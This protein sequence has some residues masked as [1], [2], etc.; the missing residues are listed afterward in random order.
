MST[1]R[2]NTL[3]NSA[4]AHLAPA[5]QDEDSLRGRVEYA[6]GA[7]RLAPARLSKGLDERLGLARRFGFRPDSPKSKAP[8]DNRQRAIVKLHFFGHGGGGAGALKA[9]VRYIAREDAGRVHELELE[10]AAR[11]KREA[12]RALEAHAGYLTRE[13]D[14]PPFYDWAEDNV[15]GAARARVW[16]REDKRHFRIILAAEEGARL[17]DHKAYVRDVMERAERALGTRL[18]WLA[19]DHFDTDNPHSHILL[20]GRRG[21]GR[22]LVLPRD[23]VRHGLRDIAREVATETLGPRRRSQEKE[24]LAREARAH[25]PT[26]LDALLDRQM[27]A[28]GKLRIAAVRAPDRDPDLTSALKARAQEL[29]RLGLA[30]ETSRNV[31]VFNPDWRARL[32]EI[33]LHLD[34]RKRIMRERAVRAAPALKPP[35]PARDR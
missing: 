32:Q 33:E 9:H 26:R 12:E 24:A 19:V 14:G 22:A 3:L 5:L 6:R 7:A 30:R 10:E 11:T 16:A 23:F 35:G 1:D 15:D 28:D 18:E 25:R 34:V 20:R 27:D 21:N 2:L 8:F 13:K 29:A 17:P 4:S 31:L